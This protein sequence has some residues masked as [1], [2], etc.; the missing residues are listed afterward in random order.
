MMACTHTTTTT[1]RKEDS[2]PQ[3]SKRNRKNN[4]NGHGSSDKPLKSRIRT[5]VDHTYKD[6]AHDT[7]SKEYSAAKHDVA[8]GG[9]T[10]PFPEKLHIM[11]GAALRKGFDSVISWQ[12]HG[13]CF[14]IH[15]KTPFVQAIMP[16]YVLFSLR[17]C[18][19]VK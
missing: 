14:L 6:H 10:I 5:V 2:S 3:R 17:A 1:T 4:S 12:P 7:V 16:R 19:R 18:L 8:K 13:R 15:E 9:V 11:L